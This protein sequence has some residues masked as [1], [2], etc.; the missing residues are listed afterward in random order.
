MIA[1][2]S[3]ERIVIS[4]LHSLAQQLANLGEALIDQNLTPWTGTRQE[5]DPDSASP[6]SDAAC[7]QLHIDLSEVASIT[8]G[9]AVMILTFG[10]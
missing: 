2:D 6:T 4:H 3:F 9:E 7:D 10:D 5:L 8:Q 1:E